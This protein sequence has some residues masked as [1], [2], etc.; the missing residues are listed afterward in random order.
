[1][2]TYPLSTESHLVERLD[3]LAQ[4][5]GRL[6]WVIRDDNRQHHHG[7]VKLSSSPLFI[8]LS[9]K[10]N[11]GG[12]EQLVGLYRLNL[13]ELLARNL[14]RFEKE[15]EVGD[16]IRLRFYRGDEGIVYIQAR[17]DRPSLPIGSVKL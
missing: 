2:T 3:A 10:P 14:V 17:G 11:H 1:V 8:E 7:I 13:P 12:P 16:E 15:N 6:R 4:G 9:W 5:V